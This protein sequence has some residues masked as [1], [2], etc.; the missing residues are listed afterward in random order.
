MLGAG[1]YFGDYIGTLPGSVPGSSTPASFLGTF[2]AQYEAG[3]FGGTSIYVAPGPGPGPDPDPGPG[4][5]PAPEI[6]T[7]QVPYVIG[8]TPDVAVTRIIQAGLTPFLL[9][10]AGAITAQDPPA[11]VFR[12]RGSAV[13]LTPGGIIYGAPSNRRRGLPIYQAPEGLQ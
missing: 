3:Y 13:T 2:L 9:A 6:V 10:G 11:F 5:G 7:V 12:A 4:P 8:K 1:A